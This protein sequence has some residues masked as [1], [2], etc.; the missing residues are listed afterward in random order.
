MLASHQGESGSILG[1]VAPG[2]SHVGIVPDDAAGR[3]VFS[4]ISLFP[5][6]LHFGAALFSPRFI[7]IGSYDLVYP[8]FVLVARAYSVFLLQTCHH[9]GCGVFIQAFQFSFSASPY[10]SHLPLEL[11]ICEVLMQP[12]ASPIPALSC[13]FDLY[14]VCASISAD[15]LITYTQP[16]GQDFLH[17]RH[18]FIC[19]RQGD[20]LGFE[21]CRGL[22]LLK[23]VARAASG[24]GSPRGHSPG[25]V[26]AVDRRVFSGNS[27]FPL[28]YIPERFH[29]H[30][31][32][33]ASFRNTLSF[34]IS[35]ILEFNDLQA[36]LNRLKYKYA[37]INCTLVVCCHSGRR[38]L[39]QHSPG[40]AEQR[41]DQWLNLAGAVTYHGDTHPG[42][43]AGGYSSSLAVSV[44]V[45]HCADD[46]VPPREAVVV[47]AALATGVAVGGLLRTPAPTLAAT[48]WQE[49]HPRRRRRAGGGEQL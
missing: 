45:A 25:I 42:V 4:G 39:G 28:P 3:R 21:K 17:P 19:R 7:L 6:P 9:A 13:L 33:P 43:G 40:G 44:L 22:I 5:T 18:S 37:D 35:K 26:D 23:R 34:R 29:T 12:A 24:L 10:P 31:A 46:V 32:S 48:A 47:G 36:R 38:R 41:V 11:H 15:I 16:R 20:R 8:R 1:P 14:V 2:F 27:R 30:L 49:E